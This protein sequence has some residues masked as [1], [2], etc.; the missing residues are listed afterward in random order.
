M[1][2]SMILLIAV[3][4]ST[5]MVAADVDVVEVLPPGPPDCVLVDLLVDNK[6]YDVNEAC[7]ADWHY[8]PDLVAK[9]LVWPSFAFIALMNSSSSSS[10][11]TGALC[12]F[13]SANL[14]H[15]PGFLPMNSRAHS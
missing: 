3:L 4:F 1:R 11:T 10:C 13:F 8:F 12:P 15:D 14:M 7:I 9:K 2:L 5:P 6:T